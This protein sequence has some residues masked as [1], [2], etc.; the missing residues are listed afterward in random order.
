MNTSISAASSPLTNQQFLRRQAAGWLLDAG[1]VDARTTDPFRLPSG[2]TTPVYMDGSRLISFPTIRRELMKQGLQRLLDAGALQGLSGV[3]GGESSGIAFAAWLAEK[4]DLPLQYVR[5]R[6]VGVRQIEGV[7]EQGGKVLL[8]DDMVSAGQYKLSFID[9]L[10]AEG[11]RVEDLFVVFDYGCLG[12]AP[13][14]QQHGVRVHALCD[15]R[16]VLEQARARGQFS[17][18]ALQTWEEFLQAP[19]EWSI[20]HGGVGQ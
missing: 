9:A 7:V 6:A 20:A 8:V 11:A 3:A 12:A 14:L 13:V 2:W 16:D 18:A 17:D 10:R 4:M 19:A 15:W 5:K 1:C